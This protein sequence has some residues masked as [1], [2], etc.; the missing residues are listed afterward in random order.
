MTKGEITNEDKT[1]KQKVSWFCQSASR[2]TWHMDIRLDH[3]QKIKVGGQIKYVQ[4][5]GDMNEAD[6]FTKNMLPSI[7]NSHVAQNEEND[8]YLKQ[9]PSPMRFEHK[10]ALDGVCHILDYCTKFEH[11]NKMFGEKW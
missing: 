2:H 10:R 1:Q 3:T 5:L 11:S 4:Q 9:C 8:M 7:F 6:T